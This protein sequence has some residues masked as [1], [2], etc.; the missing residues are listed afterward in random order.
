[1]ICDGGMIRGDS[2]KVQVPTRFELMLVESKPTVITNYT[3]GPPIFGSTPGPGTSS[4]LKTNHTPRPS[5]HTN[6]QKYYNI[7][8]IFKTGLTYLFSLLQDSKH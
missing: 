8:T 3:M 2:K 5:G 7:T 4:T 6:L 1:M